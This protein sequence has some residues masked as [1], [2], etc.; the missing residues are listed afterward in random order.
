MTSKHLQPGE[1]WTADHRKQFRI[2]AQELREGVVWI[3]Y[4]N[5]LTLQ[6]HDC[7]VEAFI[8]RFVWCG[9]Q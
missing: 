5:C 7:R 9:N 1:L 2:L 8:S 6:V 4:E 3:R